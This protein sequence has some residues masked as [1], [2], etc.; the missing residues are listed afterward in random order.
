MREHLSFA[1]AEV[2][3]DPRDVLELQGIPRETPADERLRRIH[4][5]SLNLL[6]EL[7]EPRAVLSEISPGEFERIYAGD[8]RNAPAT[9]LAAIFPRGGFLALFAAT[10]GPAVGDKIS[11][12]FAARDFALGSMLDAAA[13]LATERAGD[14]IEQHVAELLSR[15]DVPEGERHSLRYSPGYCGWHMS[16]Q[17][18]LFDALDPGEIGIA[19]RESFLMEPLK[20]MSGVV[21]AGPA[22]I[23]VFRPD[24][25]F[26][27]ECRTKGCRE[28]MRRVLHDRPPD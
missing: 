16:G 5:R 1:V 13:S 6:N 3:P 10:L 8:G 15:R 21:V 19:L 14:A 12:L 17:R 22:V 18:A 28:R 2:Q 25:A 7:A 27:A 9:P 11:A 23:H 26:C 4:D 20:S 24:Y